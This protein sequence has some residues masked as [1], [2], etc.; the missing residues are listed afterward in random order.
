MA[1]RQTVHVFLLPSIFFGAYMLHGGGFL[2]EEAGMANSACTGAG[3]LRGV[4]AGCIQGCRRCAQK[5]ATRVEVVH[6]R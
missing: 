4:R 3:K 1:Y 6:G 2:M 5:G